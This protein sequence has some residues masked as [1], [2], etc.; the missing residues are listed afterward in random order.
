MRDIRYMGLI[1][2]LWLIQTD[3]TAQITV[4]NELKI[5]YL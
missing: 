4:V 1:Y 3:V 2:V 5:L